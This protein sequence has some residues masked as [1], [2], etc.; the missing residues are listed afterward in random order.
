MCSAFSSKSLNF[1]HPQH[2][3]PC[4]QMPHSVICNLLTSQRVPLNND[5]SL[6]ILR[7]FKI[8]FAMLFVREIFLF[9]TRT[10]AVMHTVFLPNCHKEHIYKEYRQSKRDYC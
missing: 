9:T 2:Y 4:I 5:I 7:Y 8:N 10:L 1:D 6:L 3:L